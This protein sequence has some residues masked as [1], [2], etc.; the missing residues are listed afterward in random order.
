MNYRFFVLRVPLSE[1]KLKNKTL[2]LRLLLVCVLFDILTMRSEY[3]G[4]EAKIGSFVI[5]L[6]HRYW[7]ADHLSPN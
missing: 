1:S 4:S 7:F 2:N 6:E 5:D 3:S